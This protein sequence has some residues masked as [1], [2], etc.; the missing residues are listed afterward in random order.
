M[1]DP[2][3]YDL[4]EALLVANAHRVQADWSL[5][6][7]YQVNSAFYGAPYQV[8]PPVYSYLLLVVSRGLGLVLPHSIPTQQI[9]PELYAGRLI[10]LLA[11]L[12]ITGLIG[13]FVYDLGK[14]KA[15]ALACSAIFL[16]FH[17]IYYFGAFGRV[18]ALATALSLAGLYL[19]FKYAKQPGLAVYGAVLLFSLA[20]FTKQSELAAPVASCLYLLGAAKR[21]RG[22]LFTG[23]LVFL[24]LGLLGLLQFAS[25]G[26]YL[27]HVLAQGFFPFIPI[28]VLTSFAVVFG[29]YIPIWLVAILGIR[30]LGF[31]QP[32]LILFGLFTFLLSFSVGKFGSASYYFQELIAF[33]CIM[34]ALFDG[35]AVFSQFKTQPVLETKP[36]LTRAA[37]LVRTLRFGAVVALALAQ[38]LLFWLLQLQLIG[39][40]DFRSSMQPAYREAAE[41]SQAAG[42]T[43]SI[44]TT[45]PAVFLIAG[46]SDLVWDVF[47]YRFGVNS[48]Y[49]S[50]QPFV[51]DLNRH[52]YQLIILEEPLDAL[53]PNTDTA[54][55]PWPPHFVELMQ[56]NYHLKQ[57]L[58]RADGKPL[59]YIYETV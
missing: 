42:P 16:C 10:T 1:L 58:Y 22:L 12:A 27:F 8:Y 4:G 13:L 5:A 40:V 23:A 31:R 18:E 35:V 26:R 52:R 43:A 6:N 9:W 59:F 44:F 39:P 55:N 25:D 34:V 17:P 11:I 57:T 7:F 3:V 54:P 45:N 47:L 48:G 46:R 33:G 53:A 21:I 14:R 32:L 29:V 28:T 24:N 36:T 19:V 51:D 37:V 20:F 2:L 56:S 49:W 41:L 38:L 15:T 30:K 50:W